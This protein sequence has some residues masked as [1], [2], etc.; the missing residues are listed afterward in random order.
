[1]AN[2]SIYDDIKIVVMDVDGTLTDGIYQISDH[3]GGDSFVAKSFYTKD[4]YA[5]EQ[6]LKNDID[7][8]IVTQSHDHVIEKQISRICCHS[9][10]W[11]DMVAM[12]KL[13]VKTAVDNKKEAIHAEILTRNDCG[14]HNVA[15]IGDAE[16]DIECMKKA[17]FTGCPFDAIE[18]V[19]EESIYI[20]D[21]P[22]GRGAV[23]DFCMNILKKRDKENR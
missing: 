13:K 10:F 21:F 18:E 9:K 6:L 1:M 23:Y 17:L 11:T 15:Y 3:R 4:F 7:V 22:G 20:S 19:Y 2:M 16:N 8:W 14:W 12:D 5:I